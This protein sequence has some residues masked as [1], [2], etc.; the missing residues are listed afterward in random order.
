MRRTLKVAR[1]EYT[2]TAR[3][4]AFII[5]TFLAPLLIV[6]VV[7]FAARTAP[8]GPG[9]RPPQ[10]I[11]VIDLTKQL[12]AEI[13]A[14][15][16]EHNARHAD[17][18]ILQEPA[19]HAG[20]LT[21]DRARE[22]VRRGELAAAVLVQEDVL[23]GEGKIIVYTRASRPTDIDLL[24]VVGRILNRA[25][26][27]RRCA[28]RNLSPHLLAEVRRRVPVEHE[29]GSPGRT[30][31]LSQAERLARMMV[32]FFF[33]FLMF[34]GIYAVGFHMVSVIVEEKS[35]RV[36]EVLL[37]SLSPSELMAGKIMGLA[38]IGLTVIGLW[39]A[40]AYL[41]AR[42]QGLHVEV[43][44]E[45]VPYFV[46]YYV[47]GFLLFAAVFAAVG[48]IC[49]TIREAQSL[50]LPV[51]FIFV[52]PLTLWMSLARN[53]DGSLAT[54]LSYIPPLTSIVMILRLAA[55]SAASPVGIALSIVLLAASIVAVVWV[56]AKVFRTG[57]LMYGKRPRIGEVLRWLVRK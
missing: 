27:E 20:G 22:R 44:A 38:A 1:R 34:M 32:P 19:K 6:G 55:G 50:L 3:T 21:A 42:W 16:D 40:T 13:A 10:K 41:A 28:L 53:P 11:T 31:R 14:A 26:V 12:R 47:L 57:I 7:Y 30:Q 35:S 23:D 2:E 49:N 48:S 51:T 45:I 29:I 36:I 52:V 37:S 25:I 15:F 56:A 17:G 8:G 46:V 33:V 18:R 9:A 24:S 4:K 39:G 5:G 43:A 54:T